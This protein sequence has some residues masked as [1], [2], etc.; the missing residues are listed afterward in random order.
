MAEDHSCSICMEVVDV[1][2]G[3]VRPCQGSAD[4]MFCERCF[5]DWCL[6]T[7][8]G[9]RHLV[10]PI[11]RTRIQE[12]FHAMVEGESRRYFY[13]HPDKLWKVL[14]YRAGKFHGMQTY[15]FQH[16]SHQDYLELVLHY[17]NGK[18]DG[19]QQRYYN[20][21]RWRKKRGGPSGYILKN[22]LM[23][24]ATYRKG[25]CHG[26]CREWH[27]NGRLKAEYTMKDGFLD[28]EGLFYNAWGKLF[29][30]VVFHRGKVKEMETEDG[31][32]I[33][34]TF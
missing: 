28:G 3:M 32:K 31:L 18:L 30:K 21:Y 10:C 29:S 14:N 34:T 12:D 5:R 2:E 16:C 24:E 13:D 20:E 25:L 1:A 23:R 19:V 27:L 33:E 6:E 7:K 11:C 4:H 17:E 9:Q 8:I 15:Y 26:V 22:Q